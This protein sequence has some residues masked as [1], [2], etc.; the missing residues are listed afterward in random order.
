MPRVPVY[1]NRDPAAGDSGD[2]YL[3]KL[4]KYI[5]G[6][7]LAFYVPILAIAGVKSDKT[8][9]FLVTAVGIVGT[10]VWLIAN[11]RSSSPAG[12]APPVWFYVLAA[13]AFVAWA[14]GTTPELASALGLTNVLASIV[15]PIAVFIIPGIDLA[16]TPKK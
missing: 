3:E 8:A 14:I 6:E 1:P 11:A 5:P 10:V 15:L 7:V 16:L 13:V 2:G 12:Q 9:L 4:A